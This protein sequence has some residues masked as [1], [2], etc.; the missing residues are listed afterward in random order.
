MT[1]PGDAR[2]DAV[3]RAI[4]PHRHV[5][6]W[7]TIELERAV[8]SARRTGGAPVTPVPAPDDEHLGGRCVVIRPEGSDEVVILLEPFTEGLLA[9]ALARHG[10]GLVVTYV[11]SDHDASARLRAAGIGLSAE[12]GGPLGPGRLVLG[13]DRWGPHVVA[14]HRDRAVGEPPAATIEP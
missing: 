3:R 4:G 7:G 8:R 11:L 13:G 6:G 10:E 1:D 12:A 9:A 14:V 5:V 2:L